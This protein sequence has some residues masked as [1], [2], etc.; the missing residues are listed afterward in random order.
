MGSPSQAQ[1]QEIVDRNR[2]LQARYSAIGLPAL[3]EAGSLNQRMLNAE[4]VTPG[5]ENAWRAQGALS[6]AAAGDQTMAAVAGRRTV[7]TGNFASLFTPLQQG[8]L[9]AQAAV[10]QKLGFAKS[11][12][13]NQYGAI[14]RLLGG[15]GQT[16]SQALRAGGTEVEALRYMPLRNPW[17]Q[18]AATIGSG[19]YSAYGAYND[20]LARRPP[21]PAQAGQQ[22]TP[23]TLPWNTG[24]V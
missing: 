8:Q 18:G 10:G 9:I 22:G 17:V 6:Q 14:A 19:A 24:G 11:A 16:G 15:A 5:L 20:W 7:G 12:L 23:S 3:I 2:A 4:G 1:A 13:E 21:Q